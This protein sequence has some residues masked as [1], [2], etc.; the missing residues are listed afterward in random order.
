[1]FSVKLHSSGGD[2]VLA[3]CD[4][5]ILGSILTEG[6]LQVEVS[7]RFYGGDV[8]SRDQLLS[9]IEEATIINIMGNRIV[10]FA[11][12]EGLVQSKNVRK[13]GGVK[14]AQIVTIPKER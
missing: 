10:D 8:V 11:I 2:V 4:R 14:H 13:I 1:M 12:E 9:H 5:E 3:G 7:E 6:E